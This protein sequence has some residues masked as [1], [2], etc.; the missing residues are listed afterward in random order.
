MG[1]ARCMCALWPRGVYTCVAAVLTVGSSD[2]RLLSADQVALVA[3]D[4]RRRFEDASADMKY[5]WAVRPRARSRHGHAYVKYAGVM[6][7]C[8]CV[9][10]GGAGL[11]KGDELPARCGCALARGG[12]LERHFEGVRVA[13]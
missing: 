7:A 8:V 1:D 5:F 13:L 3:S 6:C 10:G 11:G 12:G 4:K 2:F 9:W